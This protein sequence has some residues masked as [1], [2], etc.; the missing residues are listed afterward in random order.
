[1][2]IKKKINKK[3]FSLIEWKLDQI[4]FPYQK[5]NENYYFMIYHAVCNGQFNFDYFHKNPT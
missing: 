2:R 1:M 4:S 5:D 3:F